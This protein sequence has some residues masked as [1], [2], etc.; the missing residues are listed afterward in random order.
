MNG[1]TT[2]NILWS[3]K[4]SLN[5]DDLPGARTR[6]SYEVYVCVLC[7]LCVRCTVHDTSRNS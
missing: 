1:W 5:G 6:Y 3:I 7:V 4:M 2:A